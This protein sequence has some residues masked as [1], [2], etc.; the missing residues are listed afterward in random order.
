MAT[1]TFQVAG[2]KIL[3][4]EAGWS[5]SGQFTAMAT[6]D[7]GNTADPQ[8]VMFTVDDQAPA[9]EFVAPTLS[10]TLES[11]L[12]SFQNWVKRRVPRTMAS[13][14]SLIPGLMYWISAEYHRPL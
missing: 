3:S 6:D 5:I 4:L 11:P 7:F 12:Q 8:T 10:N 1:A 13:S 14:F 9:I 2:V